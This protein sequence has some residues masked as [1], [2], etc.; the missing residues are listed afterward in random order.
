MKVCDSLS[1]NEDSDDEEYDREERALISADNWVVRFFL[2]VVEGRFLSP[3]DSV[4]DN[5]FEEGDRELG[6]RVGVRRDA[7]IC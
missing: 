4:L 6:D 3:L 5:V 2:G 7:S 1:S